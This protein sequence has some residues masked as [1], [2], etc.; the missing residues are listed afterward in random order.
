MVHVY[1]L[2]SILDVLFN[3]VVMTLA[4]HVMIFYLRFFNVTGCVM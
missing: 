4:V 2:T 1:V 3:T